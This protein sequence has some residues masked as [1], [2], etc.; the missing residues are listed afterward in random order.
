MSNTRRDFLKT[1][2]TVAAA[3]VVGPRLL[4]AST[5]LISPPAYLEAPP[6]EA[7]ASELAAEAL[8]AAKDAGDLALACADRLA[9][10]ARDAH[11]G[12]RGASI[13]CG[14]ECFGSELR[15]ECFCR[16]CFEVGRWADQR[17]RCTKQ[18]RADDRCRGNG[19]AGFQ[20]ITARI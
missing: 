9:P 2:A 11:I 20:E 5:P 14:V 3:T 19:G 12:V 7:F 15:R 1:G 17:R 8:N 10:I 6:T 4:G 13:F 16:R 18:P